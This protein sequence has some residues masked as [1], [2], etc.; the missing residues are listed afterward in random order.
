MFIR[1]VSQPN[2]PGGDYVRRY[3]YNSVDRGTVREREST[4]GEGQKGNVIM[5]LMRYM[6]N[7][8]IVFFTKF[9][10]LCATVLFILNKKKIRII[11]IIIN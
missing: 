9:F 2:A 11:I 3:Y 4:S 5:C 7:I 8:Y 6:Y 1:S 10:L